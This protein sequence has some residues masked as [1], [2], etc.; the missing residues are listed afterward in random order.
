MMS[1]LHSLRIAARMLAA[2]KLRT[3]LA[4]L[5]VF[6]GALMLTLV[7]HI[8]QSV[9]LQIR[10]EARRLGSD[11]ITIQPRKAD[12][13]RAPKGEAQAAALTEGDYAALM[14]RTPGI[15][16]SAPFVLDKPTIGHAAVKTSC[17]ATAT[18]AIFPLLRSFTPAVGRFFTE[19]DDR[20]LAR[21]CV[22]GSSLA[23]RLFGDPGKALGSFISVGATEFTVIGVMEPKGL[24]G[25][26]VNLDE[27]L[28]FPLQTYIH[29]LHYRET[30]SGIWF[31]LEDGS[32]VD[33]ASASVRTLLRARHHIPSYGKDDFAIAF[34][35]QVNQMRDQAIDLVRTLGYV[36]SSLSFAIGTLGILSIMTLIVRSRRLEIGIRRAVG[37]TKSHILRQFMLEATLLS[38]A[39]G[40]AGVA[41]AL[42]F[43][44]LIFA[45][46]G[47][48]AVFSPIV[49]LGV[50]LISSACGML[51][52][53]YPAWRATR[54]EI[55]DV[56]KSS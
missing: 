14:A 22:L 40:V 19:Y 47:L 43:T 29:R 34:S 9:S 49:T 52:G 27:Q 33:A 56:L 50:C 8:L 38:S 17:P 46:G 2:F 20:A 13:L 36:G 55:L 7:L 28:F 23:E 18:T 35:K 21:V 6:L 45:G 4:I 10:Q 44:R 3:A 54:V 39:G 48:P 30:L 51:A 32:P 41:C 12:F 37:A 42:L 15:A 24:D 26:S 31:T 11:I 1:L 16:L 53:L 5:G 25:S